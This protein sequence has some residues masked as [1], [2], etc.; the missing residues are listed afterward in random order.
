MFGVGYLERMQKIVGDEKNIIKGK[1]NI[2]PQKNKQDN[3][4][5]L[6]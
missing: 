3:M 4:D 5:K 2:D 6:F 1:I